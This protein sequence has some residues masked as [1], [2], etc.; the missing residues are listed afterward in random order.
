MHLRLVSLYRTGERLAI[1]E[2]EMCSV[3]VYDSGS[4]IPYVQKSTINWN[5]RDGLA[6]EIRNLNFIL[7][8]IGTKTAQV[9]HPVTA[10]GVLPG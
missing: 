10:I 9:K 3:V 4:W 5:R 8:E 2:D 1:T 6:L 7:W